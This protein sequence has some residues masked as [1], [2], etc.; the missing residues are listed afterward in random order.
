MPKTP[1]QREFTRSANFFTRAISRGI[2]FVKFYAQLI[3]TESLLFSKEQC[4]L[5]TLLSHLSFCHKSFI[6]NLSQDRT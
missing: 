6:P 1:N 3:M 4:L 2:C 5:S